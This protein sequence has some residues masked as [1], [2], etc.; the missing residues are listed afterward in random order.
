LLLL[1]APVPIADIHPQAAL[2]EPVLAGFKPAS[3]PPAP[4]IEHRSMRLQGPGLRPEASAAGPS[5]YYI[6][7]PTAHEQLYLEYI[8]RARANPADEAL[9]LANTTDRDAIQ[10]YT[11]FEV[12]LD[13]MVSDLSSL[14]AAPPLALNA[15]LL[16]AAR[17]HSQDMLANGFQGHVGTDGSTLASRVNAQ[18]YAW[19]SLGENVFSSALSVEHGHAAFEVD[20][21][22]AN[23]SIGGMQDPPGHRLSIHEALFREIGIGVV[24]GK[25]G[26]FG[27]QVVTQNFGT[28][29]GAGPFLTGVVYYDF[30]GNNFYDLGEGVG[31]VTV[32]VAGSSYYAISAGSGGYAV[33]LPGNGNYTATFSAAALPQARRDFTVSGGNN[34]K[35]DYRPIYFPPVISGPARP[36]I[37]QE[38][39]YSFTPVGGATAYQW[40]LSKSIPVSGVIE[41]AENGFS[42][43]I[44]EVSPG[45][46]V[47]D[48]VWYKSGRYS[49]HLA[50]P[51][52]ESQSLTLD[53]VFRL[54]NG[55]ELVFAS[56]LGWA[57]ASQVARAQVSA[58]AGNTWHTV[59][60]QTGT[61]GIGQ[62]GFA[63]QRISLAS[64]AGKEIMVRFRYDFET[65]KYFSTTNPGHGFHLDDIGLVDAV[66]VTAE[67]VSDIPS[68][69][70]FSFVPPQI[71][72]YLL[73]IR[74]LLSGRP[75]DW[76]SHKEVVAEVG[77]PQP[78]VIRIV[79]VERTSDS[80]V[81]IDFTVTNTGS[82]AYQLLSASN[83]AGPWTAES[84]ATISN[85]GA[86]GNLRALTP[87]QGAV[88]RFFRIASN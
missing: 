41:G 59:W 19:I 26:N 76:D 57:T 71:G 23:G 81:Q 37:L 42:R 21:G 87:A 46:V 16:A 2:P 60:S 14:P 72:P 50:H 5:L 70:S 58:D 8:N 73:S 39:R 78:P 40:R 86:A 49:F 32:Q 69:N 56:L 83:P 48:N 24:H 75:L 22:G 85:Q 44:P 64:W 34:V 47:L 4:P 77:P 3:P 62:A 6:G 28:G 74:P 25:N 12:D 33:P 65:G 61:G 79:S 27:P 18:N 20:W 9:R 54:G 15:K 31:G 10:A 43:V 84:S 52:P 88:V 1:A 53:R 82:V 38:N 13:L 80:R 30:N 63:V 17:L 11:H 45:Y 55:A 51:Q 29:P 68:G 67:T 36:F 35:L 66:E 7:E